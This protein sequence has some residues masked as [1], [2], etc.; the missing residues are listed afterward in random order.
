MGR[1]FPCFSFFRGAQRHGF[2]VSNRNDKLVCVCVYVCVCVCLE[3]FDCEHSPKQ[4]LPSSDK[5]GYPEL[6]RVC[7]FL[8]LH[9]LLFS[10]AT[11]M[12]DSLHHVWS[13]FATFAFSI[14]K[15]II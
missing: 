1:T 10:F 5:K 3:D 9:F 11:C 4:L 6:Y 8:H 15:T 13:F 2:V 12:R 7:M 14:D